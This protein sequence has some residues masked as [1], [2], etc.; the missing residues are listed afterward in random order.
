[1][2]LFYHFIVIGSDIFEKSKKGHCLMMN[3]ENDE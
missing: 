3:D 1:M 2:K